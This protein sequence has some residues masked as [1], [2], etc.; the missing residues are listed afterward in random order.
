M[1]EKKINKPRLSIF[2][3]HD[4]AVGLEKIVS[5][6]FKAVQLVYWLDQDKKTKT[7]CI[8]SIISLEW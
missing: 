2:N 1:I 7:I 6:T 3:Y 8:L 4:L 5:N